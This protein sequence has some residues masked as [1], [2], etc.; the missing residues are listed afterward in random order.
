MKNGEPLCFLAVTYQEEVMIIL[1]HTVQSG[2]KC[3]IPKKSLT[4][5][6]EKPARGNTKNGIKS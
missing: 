2:G 3:I 4:S 5:H 6:Y 1:A